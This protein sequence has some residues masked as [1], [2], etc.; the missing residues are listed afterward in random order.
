MLSPQSSVSPSTSPSPASLALVDKMF[1]GSDNAAVAAAMA[2]AAAAIPAPSRPE[3]APPASDGGV[4][5]AAIEDCTAHHHHSTCIGC[6]INGEP[7]CKRIVRKS[8]RHGRGVVCTACDTC[9]VRCANQQVRLWLVQ[10]SKGVHSRMCSA[11]NLC[12][13]SALKS[14]LMECSRCPKNHGL[15]HFAA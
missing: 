1:S 5:S 6:T 3:L 11:K 8:K 2:A 10:F 4:P 14:A 9:I 13:R 12:T 15:A 7:C